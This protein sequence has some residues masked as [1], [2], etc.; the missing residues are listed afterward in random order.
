MRGLFEFCLLFCEKLES[1]LLRRKKEEGKKK[2]RGG[3]EE[4]ERIYEILC[5]FHYIV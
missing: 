4:E 2:E 1:K 5:T 3:G